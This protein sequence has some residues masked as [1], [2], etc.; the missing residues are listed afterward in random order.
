MLKIWV[1][2]YLQFYSEI[3]SCKPVIKQTF[4]RPK[5]WQDSGLKHIC[6]ISMYTYPMLFVTGGSVP[7]RKTDLDWLPD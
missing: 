5:I 6:A 2:K 4:L 7:K 3:C 1:R